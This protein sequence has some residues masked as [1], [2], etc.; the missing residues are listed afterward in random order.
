MKSQLQKL[1]LDLDW[2][3][4]LATCNENYY[5]YQQE[6]FIDLYNANLAYKKDALVNWDPVDQTYLPMSKLLTVKDGGLGLML[7]KRICLNGFLR[8][9][10]MLKNF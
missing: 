10:I 2:D 5:H 4:E 7:K 3:R 9:H 6:L 1:E 8:S